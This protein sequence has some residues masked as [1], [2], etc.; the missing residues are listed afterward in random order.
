M[1]RAFT[2]IEVMV[3]LSILAIIAILAYNF[4]GSTMKE[5]TL[6][7]NVTKAYNDMRIISDAMD[8]Y[9]L[10]NGG[11]YANNADLVGAGYL[12]AMPVPD[13]S[14]LDPSYCPYNYSTYRTYMDFGGP[15]TGSDVLVVVE[16]G[17]TDE[18]C[19]AF[20][21]EYSEGLGATIWDYC[22]DG[23]NSMPI[24]GTDFNGTALCVD[25]YC[26]GTDDNEIYMLVNYN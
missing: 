3:V 18:F 11:S 13:C 26:G 14:I 22:A 1:K 12:K 24:Q 23:S 15:T 25:F 2:L 21:A 9:S 6:K 19:K 7:K 4:F 20:N 8:Q 5:A 17:I 16:G 10:D